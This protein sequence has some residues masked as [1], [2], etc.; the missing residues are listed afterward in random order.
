MIR[1][2]TSHVCVQVYDSH[3]K[4]VSQQYHLDSHCHDWASAASTGTTRL[5]S[6]KALELKQQKPFQTFIARQDLVPSAI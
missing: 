2:C 5:P 3:T 1:A 6:F 4:L